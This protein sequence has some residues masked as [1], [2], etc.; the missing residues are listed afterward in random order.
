M[1]LLIFDTILNGHHSD[2]IG[3]LVHYWHSAQVPG[4]LYV[5]TPAGLAAALPEKYATN[6]D[7]HFVELTEAEVQGSQSAGAVRRSFADWNLYVKHAERIQPTCAL[8]MYADIFQLGL[9]LG[10]KSPC[11]V[12]G[13]Y[14]RPSFGQSSASGS[15]EKLVVARKRFLLRRML[16]NPSLST[17]FCLDHSAVPAIQALT[18]AVKVLPLADPVR[19]YKRAPEQVEKLRS[20]LKIESGR[21]VFLLFG[22]LDDRKGIEPTLDAIGQ[23][24][25][26]ESRQVTLIL[27]GPMASDYRA[28]IESRLK[29]LCTKAQ[30]IGHFQEIKGPAIQDFFELT[31]F[32]LTLYQRHVGMSSIVV[33]AALSEKPII[34]SDFGYMGHLVT[35]EKLGT[36]VDSQS[37]TAIAAALRS[38]LQGH[39]NIA[40]ASLQAFAQ[41]NTDT[42]FVRQLLDGIS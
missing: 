37:P 10:K 32:V 13:I 39:L 17:L 26:S 29:E 41:K 27:A 25:E 1:K 6:S 7:I 11:P 30:I 24:S 5:V 42:A 9:W 14:F 34:S 19:P 22:W 40:P 38:A 16:S 36:V 23:L 12:S 4:E 8:L 18:D 31:D 2:Y 15:R 3:H 20:A 21:K 35:S 33:R 28:T